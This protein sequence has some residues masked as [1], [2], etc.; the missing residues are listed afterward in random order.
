MAVDVGASAY[1]HSVIKKSGDEAV[2]GEKRG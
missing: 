2:A 1:V